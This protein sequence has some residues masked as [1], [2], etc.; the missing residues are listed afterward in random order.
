M[1]GHSRCTGHPHQP[2]T[3]KVVSFAGFLSGQAPQVSSHPFLRALNMCADGS[4]WMDTKLTDN[5]VN[6]FHA[7][8]LDE[9]RAPFSPAVWEKPDGCETNLKQVWFPGAHS[10]VGGG[11]DDT[12]SANISLAWMMDQLAGHSDPCSAEDPSHWIEF[13]EEYLSYLH[14]LHSD[15][16]VSNPPL[17]SW[18]NG[19]LFKSFKFPMNLAGWINRT[20]GRYRKLNKITLKPKHGVLL[21]DTNEFIHASV[22]ARMDLGGA[23]PVDDNKSWH[24]WSSFVSLIHKILLRDGKAMYRPSALRGW[25]LQD[26]HQYHDEMAVNNIKLMRDEAT[27]PWWE[28]E[29]HDRYIRHGSKL[30]EDRLGKFELQLLRNFDAAPEI[31]ASNRGLMNVASLREVQAL[32]RETG[33][34]ATI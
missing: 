4:R 24:P 9:H 27:S 34:S 16:Y 6:A 8:A 3:A 11:Y 32:E 18:A 19:A 29:G 23:A 28:W 7:L 1:L 25:K 33:R 31:E 14:R 22:R 13:S 12:G 30:H 20:P 17:L 26:G 21:R 15:W 5:V 2:S 10:G